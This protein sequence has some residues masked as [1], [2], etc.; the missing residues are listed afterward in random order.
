MTV[1]RPGSKETVE[2]E[3]PPARS[4]Q[5]E[6]QTENKGGAASQK[7]TSSQKKARRKAAK[8]QAAAAAEASKASPTQGQGGDSKT[9]DNAQNSGGQIT[10]GQNSTSS[11]TP[12][13]RPTSTSP[14]SS[15]ATE[16]SVS[17][18]E[19]PTF[20]V[21]GAQSRTGVSDIFGDVPDV[22]PRWQSKGKKKK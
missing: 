8:A 14:R 20:G 21:G 1:S 17:P 22:T 12:S 15:L 16:A 7:A 2:V 11:I 9:S 5:P 13:P 4:P 3:V 6:Q 18:L 10:P 19:P